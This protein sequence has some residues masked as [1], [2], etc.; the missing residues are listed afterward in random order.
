MKKFYICIALAI[1][2]LTSGCV[3]ESTWERHCTPKV[4]LSDGTIITGPAGSGRQPITTCKPSTEHDVWGECIRDRSKGDHQNPYY[5]RPTGEC[6]P[7]DDYRTWNSFLRTKI[8][9][10][11]KADQE[12]KAMQEKANIFLESKT[13]HVDYNLSVS[14]DKISEDMILQRYEA[15]P[16]EHPNSSTYIPSYGQTKKDEPIWSLVRGPSLR[17]ED[18][19]CKKEMVKDNVFD[20]VSPSLEIVRNSENL[21]FAE[22]KKLR[23]EIMFQGDNWYWPNKNSACSK[24]E[25]N[26]TYRTQYRSS[27]K[28][29]DFGENNNCPGNETFDK[30]TGDDINLTEN[31]DIPRSIPTKDEHHIN[32]EHYPA[33]LQVCKD[34]CFSQVFVEQKLEQQR[35]SYMY[36][37][38]EFYKTLGCERN[39]SSWYTEEEMTWPCKKAPGIN[40]FWD[41][42]SCTYYNGYE[43][44]RTNIY[45]PVSVKVPYKTGKL[46]YDSGSNA[47]VPEVKFFGLERHKIACTKCEAEQYS[48]MC[49]FPKNEIFIVRKK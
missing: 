13:D 31:Y 6:K 35:C 44:R 1:A 5:V 4:E 10:K 14:N 41:D 39:K 25:T 49:R 26:M 36:V 38:G 8:G 37:D 46:I 15:E 47:S 23:D 30:I 3:D 7:T 19:D 21:S 16:T 42:G 9:K 43:I 27:E 20:Q 11:W 34:K 18:E 17:S 33:E 2:L 45:Q 40:R 12:F 28:P 29:S 48:K 24:A 22:V 32:L